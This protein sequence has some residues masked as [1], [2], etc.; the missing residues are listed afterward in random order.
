MSGKTEGRQMWQSRVEIELYSVEYFDSSF[1]SAP[2]SPFPSAPDS[3]F[4]SPPDSPFPSA[5]DSLAPDYQDLPLLFYIF[6]I[7]VRG[8]PANKVTCSVGLGT[9]P[10]Q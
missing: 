3:P 7:G 6:S 4:P 9:K 2:D 10:M 5:P 1:P 8:E